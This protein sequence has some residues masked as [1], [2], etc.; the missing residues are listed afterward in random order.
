[1]VP[2]HDQHGSPTQTNTLSLTNEASLN[3]SF[4]TQP[5]QNAASTSSTNTSLLQHNHPNHE[6]HIPSTSIVQN[7]PSAFSLVTNTHSMV[8]RGK[9]GNLKPK[10]FLVVC[11]PTNLKQVLAEPKWFEAMQQEYNALLAKNT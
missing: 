5:S 8:T 2:P 10:T 11:E 9:S 3:P 7:N 1:M 4:H 6:P